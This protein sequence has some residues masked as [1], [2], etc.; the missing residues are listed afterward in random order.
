MSS[1]DDFPQDVAVLYKRLAEVIDAYWNEHPK[2]DVNEMHMRVYNACAQACATSISY[3]HQHVFGEEN[4][5]DHN[6]TQAVL[7]DIFEM[8]DRQMK[9][10]SERLDVPLNHVRWD[11]KGDFQG[12]EKHDG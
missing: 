12:E 6:Y 5:D 1:L 11:R 8:V 7:D 10:I 9:A 3:M 2:A 4:F